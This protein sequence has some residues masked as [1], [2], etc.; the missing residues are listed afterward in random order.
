[1]L[2]TH[3]IVIDHTEASAEAAL[4]TADAFIRDL[5]L[6]GKDAIHLRLLA[7]ETIG[8]VRAMAGD[9]SALFWLEGDRGG[10]RIRLSADTRMNLK[11]KEDLLSVSKSGRNAAVR[12]FMGRIGE[13]IED[14]L[15][16]FDDVMTE[17]NKYAGGGRPYAEYGFVTPGAVLNP[18]T[19]PAPFWSLESYK[20]ALE[21]APGKEEGKTE[22]WD[23]LEKS[24]VAS[25]ADNVIVG[26]RKNSVD[27]TII[28]RQLVH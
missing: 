22:A 12:G 25:L 2:K 5:G 18:L 23:E 21:K 3:E 8:M 15:M 26:I 11:K 13:I 10:Y 19:E 1:M 6:S 14:S 28:K 17:Q 24:I 9:F 27:M 16:N 4:S 7:E 20:E